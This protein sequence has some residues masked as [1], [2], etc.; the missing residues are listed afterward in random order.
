MAKAK[1]INAK[2]YGAPLHF[3]TH[4]PYLAETYSSLPFDV[5]FL[6]YIVLAIREVL[7]GVGM[8]SIGSHE[9]SLSYCAKVKVF[10][11]LVNPGKEEDLAKPLS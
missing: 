4:C 1:K 11:M 3:S 10:L 9:Q 8:S 2:M 7:Y 6:I 5:L